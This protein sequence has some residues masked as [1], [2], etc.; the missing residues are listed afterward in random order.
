MTKSKFCK[1][2]KLTVL[3]KELQNSFFVSYPIPC[4]S[5]L[6]NCRKE[7]SSFKS[8]FLQINLFQTKILE[9][10]FRFRLHIWVR[11]DC[12]PISQQIYNYKR[13]SSNLIKKKRQDIRQL[14]TLLKIETVLLLFKY[15]LPKSCL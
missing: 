7:N 5:S 3:F 2:A 9:M 15:F 10:L 14:N 8:H 4:L 1:K 13:T 12:R 6:G 11:V